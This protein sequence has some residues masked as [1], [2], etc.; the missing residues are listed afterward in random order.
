AAR[1]CGP[2]RRPSTSRPFSSRPTRRRRSSMRRLEL[3]TFP[4]RE[5]RFGGRTRWDDGRL[6]L[7][8]DE[9][10]AVARVDPRVEA[11]ALRLPPPGAS[12]RSISPRDVLEPRVKVD[13][14]GVVYPG[15]AGRPTDLVGAGRTHR[16]GGVA[17]VEC[18]DAA[19]LT[20]TSM[21]E[22]RLWR[23]SVPGR[24]DA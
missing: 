14:G 11:A 23:R 6:D 22:S 9:L 12:A 8:P 18:L 16:L 7:D 3:G 2:S 21:A 20:E 4:V 19:R 24:T 17:V 10:L 1:R 15:V 5:V 13:G